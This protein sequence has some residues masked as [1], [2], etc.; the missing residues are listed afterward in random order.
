[1]N[2]SCRGFLLSISALADDNL[3]AASVPAVRAHLAEC[4]ECNR[5]YQEQRELSDWLR[6]G[7]P[8]A[9]PAPE[10]WSRIESRLPVPRGSLWEQLGSGLAAAVRFPEVRYV[11]ASLVLLAILSGG[12]MGR[13]QEAQPV[14]RVSAKAENP[15][16]VALKQ[17]TFPS[18][19][20]RRAAEGE[21]PFEMIRGER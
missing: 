13:I 10:V 8:D 4:P 11:A 12:F 20:A 17:E 3:D 7:F 9:D 21:N 14:P 19:L 5:L 2:R 18:S 15:F 1:M 6:A 16:L